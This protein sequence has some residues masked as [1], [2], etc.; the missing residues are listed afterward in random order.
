MDPGFVLTDTVKV[1]SINKCL[2]HWISC[3]PAYKR[4]LC[5]SRDNDETTLAIIK[6]NP[7]KLHILKIWAWLSSLCCA[8]CPGFKWGNGV[9]D[10]SGFNPSAAALWILP[11]AGDQRP[12]ADDIYLLFVCH[13]P[14]W[15][16]NEILLPNIILAKCPS[17]NLF[18]V[19]QLH[20]VSDQCNQSPVQGRVAV[21]VWL[22]C[23]WL[24]GVFAS[25]SMYKKQFS[26]ELK[27]LCL[28]FLQA[29]A[30]ESKALSDV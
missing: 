9:D 23:W 27:P 25:Q 17:A 11:A 26:G 16:L 8:G 22:L 30:N 12:P 2:A 21:N 15:F 10:S 1:R 24:A 13:W 19:T 6:G 7:N 18:T 14:V 20:Y 4:P 29:A 3:Q 28:S 5:T